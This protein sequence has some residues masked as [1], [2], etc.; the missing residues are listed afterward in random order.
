M[1][2]DFDESFVKHLIQMELDA[3]AVLG[4]N[5]V[6]A[7]DDEL[8]YF[9]ENSWQRSE[10]LLRHLKRAQ[11]LRSVLFDMNEAGKRKPPRLLKVHPNIFVCR[12]HTHAHVG[13]TCLHKT[14]TTRER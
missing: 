8:P 3:V 13:S 14:R 11:D 2:F 6:T 9:R 12:T 1:A 7:A 5:I 4:D 10:M